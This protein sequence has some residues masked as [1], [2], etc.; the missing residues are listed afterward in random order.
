MQIS[1]KTVS[2][3]V[4]HLDFVTDND[5]Y[6][7]ICLK[8]SDQTKALLP[9]RVKL[10]INYGYDSEYYEKL[11]RDQKFDSINM[12]VHKLNDL[13]IMTLNEA[14]YQKHKEVDYH[15]QTEQMDT[16]TLWWPVLQVCQC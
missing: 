2:E 16:A 7:S 12:E 1:N 9:L 4:G 10:S 11:M 8:K 5:G 6:Y 13:M 14:D 3:P 15:F